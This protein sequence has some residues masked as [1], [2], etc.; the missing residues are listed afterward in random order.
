V[1]ESD[2]ALGI[3]NGFVISPYSRYV[4]STEGSGAADACVVDT[5]LIFFEIAPDYRSVKA[6]KQ[7]QFTGITVPPDSS[8]YP[9][10][11]GGWDNDNQYVVPLSVTCSL[12]K[13]LPGTYVFNMM[14][15]TVEKK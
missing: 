3:G 14:Q 10:D 1:Y 5:R 8:V 2:T 6:L 13:G 4:A 11:V 9:T 15:L 12:N 7:E